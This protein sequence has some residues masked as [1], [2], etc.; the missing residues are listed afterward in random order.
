MRFRT[1]IPPVRKQ[2]PLTIDSGITMLGSCFTDNIGARMLDHGLNVAVNPCGVL[3][4][5]FSIAAVIETALSGE[6]IRPTAFEFLGLHRNWLFSTKFARADRT[7]A[8]SLWQKSLDSLRDHLLNDSLLIITFGTARVYRHIPSPLSPFDGIVG[9]CH[10]VP[11]E[12]EVISLSV[13]EIADRWTPLLN[14]LHELNPEMRILFTVSPIRH[15]SD[16]AHENTLSKAT[17]Q[18]AIEQMCANHD[19]ADYY[20][21]YE[22]LNDDLRDYRFYA[23]DLVHPSEMAADYI[24]QHFTSTFFSDQMIAE[25]SIR[26]K[27]IRRSRHHNITPA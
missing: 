17:L 10:K 18:L 4:N 11:K 15:L 13:K 6:S 9:N 7:E 21:A 12:F 2:L 3:Y 26:A 19:F 25:M 24:W 22:L 5:P 27:E 8:E 20:P 23:A 1:E 16:G 14:K